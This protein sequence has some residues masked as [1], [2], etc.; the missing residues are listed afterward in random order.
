M[1]ASTKWLG[2]LAAPALLLLGGAAHADSISPAE[3]SDSLAVGESVTIRKTVT[4]DAA[5]PTGALIDVHF[6]FDTSGSMERDDR[7]PLVKR[8]I[9]MLLEQLAEADRVSVVTYGNRSSLLIANA[10]ASAKAEILDTLER[11]QSGGSTN[12]GAGVN[13]GFQVAQRH[14]LTGGVNRVVLCSDGVANVGPDQ[15]Q[16]LADQVARLRGHGVTFTSIGVGTDTAGAGY[17]DAILEDLANKGDGTYH[18][19]G[20]D[21][22]ARRVLNRKHERDLLC[23]AIEEDINAE[24]W[25][26]AMT[27]VK[28]LAER[29][30]YRAEAESF[31]ERI[32]KARSTTTD[33]RVTEAIRHLD[34]MIVRLEW[35]KALEEAERIARLFPGSPRADGLRNKVVRSRE[36][37]KEDLERRFLHAAEA[38]R[39]DE[40]LEL[41]RELDGYLTEAEAAPYQELARGVI[42]KA[43][44]N[45]GVRFKLLVRDKNWREAAAVGERIIEEFPNTRMADEVRGMIDHIRERASAMSGVNGV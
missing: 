3:Y 1:N 27:L 31:R 4:V 45:L 17:D 6:L 20:S 5:P 36:R 10:P 24:D 14:F 25:D 18:F 13:L 34:A 11:L 40:A 44:E 32:E 41:L 2:R 37:Y 19:I 30:G 15:A 33:R 39:V 29:F 28:E 42:G 35:D 43:R 23:A 8:S 38:E 26:A 21:D 16:T 9:A 12:L 22:D 7:L